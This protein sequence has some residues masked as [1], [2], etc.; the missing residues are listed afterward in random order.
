MVG[1]DKDI[2]TCRTCESEFTVEGYNI[3]EDISFCPYCGHVTEPDFDEEFYDDDN[4][5]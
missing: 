4:I 5:D 3:D 2:H 1:D